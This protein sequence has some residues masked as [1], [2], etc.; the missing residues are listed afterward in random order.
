MRSASRSPREPSLPAELP[1][2]P[3]LT[4]LA[5]ETTLEELELGDCDL[6]Q[7]RAP[8]VAVRTARLRATCLAG[9]T[10]DGLELTDVEL[11]GCDLAN[12]RSRRAGWIRMRA[13]ACR[14]TGLTLSDSVLRD[15][16]I[17]GCRVDL[18]SFAGCR[19]QRVVFEDCNLA[20]TD[21]L[22]AELEAVDFSGCDLTGADLRG[23]R[24]RHC[25]LRESRLEGLQ[26]VDRLRG[27]AMPWADIVGGAAL[28]AQALGIDVLDDSAAP[29]GQ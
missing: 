27:S 22:E 25:E 2:A 24:L 15:V 29:D 11:L 18:A 23:A 21:F 1:D 20:Q 5:A 4:G 17:S 26:G 8:G 14:M 13:R 19:L 16:T 10:L 12:L 9:A 3:A 6:S 7:V 28:W